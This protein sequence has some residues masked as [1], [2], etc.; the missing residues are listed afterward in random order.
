M[1]RKLSRI[2]LIIA[3]VLAFI[4]AHVMAVDTYGYYMDI[5]ITDTSGVARTQVNVATGISGT[6][7]YNAGYIAS[8]GMDTRVRATN[9]TTDYDYMIVSNQLVI[10]IPTLGAYQSLT[11]RLYM[12]FAPVQTAIPMVLGTGGYVTT[13]DAAALEPANNFSITFS[14]YVNTAAG[15]N[16]DIYFKDTALRLYVSGAGD[17]S[18]VITA[19]GSIAPFS[20]TSDGLLQSNDANYATAR[21]SATADSAFT[22][23]DIYVGQGNDAGSYFVQRGYLYFDTSA[24]P[25]GAVISAASL[26]L[27]GANDSSA[28]DYDLTLQNGMPTYPHDPLVVADFAN[29][30]YAGSGGVFNTAGWAVGSYNVLPLDATGISWISKT[31][32]S[33]FLLRSSHDINSNA[34]GV[35]V[36]NSVGFE[37]SDTAG[38]AQDPYLSVTYTDSRTVT[39]NGVT[40]AEHTIILAA[41]GTDLTLTVDAVEEDSIALTGASVPDN[42]NNIIWLRNNVSSYADYLS[43][44]INGT[45]IVHYHPAAMISGTTLPDLEGAAQN[46]TITFGANANLNVAVGELTSYAEVTPPDSVS[47][48]TPPDFVQDM[49]QPAGWYGAGTGVGLPFYSTFNAAATSMGMTTQTLYLWFMLA[50]AAAVGVLIAIFTG[51]T[52]IAAIGCGGVIVAGVNTGILSA[53]MTLIFAILAIG[54]IY[55]A[56]RA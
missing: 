14:G 20:S 22:V 50:L 55:L 53:W 56:R 32:T 11:V 7:L 31:G 24:I 6:N 25:D 4:P 8:N 44:T 41:D 52:L 40:S 33:K 34:P 15:A 43:C 29:G 48:D 3:F 23:S 28:V 2:A 35:G 39:A 54:V 12:D 13:A 38:T 10:N 18:G 42:A 45:L 27:Y 1:K 47:G 16:K 21:G 26:Y 49:T 19:P 37:S 30:N 5:T 17:V 51:S 9:G 46:G 36:T